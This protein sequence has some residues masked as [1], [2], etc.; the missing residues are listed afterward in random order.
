MKYARFF[1]ILFCF[2]L[3]VV[4]L[5]MAINKY[6]SY[7]V[8][9]IEAERTAIEKHYRDTMRALQKELLI[10][11]ARI[12]ASEKMIKQYRSKVAA[13]EKKIKTINAPASKKE[14]E[15]RLAAMHIAT[16]PPDDKVICLEEQDAKKIV[17]D[18]EKTEIIG[19]Q[20]NDLIALNAE[21]E[22]QNTNLK[23]VLVIKDK[24]L[25]AC[26]NTMK[27]KDRLCDKQIE[28]VKPSLMEDI[29]KIGGGIGIG[30]LVGI[31]VLLL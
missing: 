3:L 28:A 8:T 29:L 1:L 9:Q 25:E 14:I 24:S 26:E 23:D 22:E 15:Q 21:L 5:L 20:N 10:K 12:A 27:D 31:V 13:S 11:N 16:A 18:L 17:V 2:V 6:T 19:E 7:R 30:I 4:F